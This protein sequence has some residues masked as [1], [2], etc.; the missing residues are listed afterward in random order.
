MKRYLSVVLLLGLALTMLG[1]LPVKAEINADYPYL[2]MDFENSSGTGVN[3]SHTSLAKGGAGGSAG[4]LYVNQTEDAQDYYVPVPSYDF[5]VGQRAKL[6]AWIKLDTSKTKLERQSIGYVMYGPSDSGNNSWLGLDSFSA[7]NLDLNSGEWVYVERFLTWDGAMTDGGM[8]DGSKT[9]T[10]PCNICPRVGQYASGIIKDA[11]AEDS[12]TKSICYWIDNITLE[13]AIEKPEGPVE[14][15]D[16]TFLL[17]AVFDSDADGLTSEVAKYSPATGPDGKPGILKIAG[18][19]G[20]YHDLQ[21]P[22]LP[23]KYNK[24]Y[25]ISMKAKA[26]S[27]ASVGVV[28]RAIILRSGR[29]DFTNDPINKHG[30]ADGFQYV[31]FEQELTTEWQTFTAYVKR[32][33]K[34]FDENP[35]SILFRF[36]DGTKIQK[37]SVDDV[38]VEEFNDC[39]TNGDFEDLKTDIPPTVNW[40]SPDVEGEDDNRY[41][42][43]YGWF[44]EGA[45]AEVSDDVSAETE[46]AKSAKITTI[47]ENGTVCQGVF[48][49]YN[50]PQEISFWAKGEGESVGKSVQVK[51][52]RFVETKDPDDA[53]DVPDT[54]ILGTDLT[55]RDTWQQ[56]TIPYHFE[57]TKP[58]DAKPGVGPRQPYISLLV[59]GGAADMTY[60][61]DDFTVGESKEANVF[62]FPYAED[63][64]VTGNMLAG[65]TLT[66]EYTYVS[67]AGKEQ[68][69]SFVRVVKELAGGDFVA[70]LFETEDNWFEYTIPK[71][72]SGSS[73]RFEI[74]PVA[75]DGTPGVIERVPVVVVKHPQVVQPSL[76]EFDAESASVTG[77]LYAENNAPGGEDLELFIVV[78]VYDKN[79]CAVRMNSK[80]VSIPAEDSAEIACTVSTAEEAGY[81]PIHKAKLYVWGGTDVFHTNMISYADTIEKEKQ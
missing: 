19:T 36:G 75:K 45:T 64:M 27:S 17:N 4:S 37:A 1:A 9:D 8:Y 78:A 62:P 76:S 28:P 14:E 52:D 56:Y 51:L 2:Y 40:A 22:M 46:G 69:A 41:G 47:Q 38:R 68:G 60:Y 67:E 48:L 18:K 13:P 12:P 77:S 79:G 59:N 73:I 29:L 70:G 44:E 54:E 53:Y 55:L 43:F 63:A 10:I 58:S 33:V 26:D 81:A 50:I 24:L 20:T 7:T 39:V 72:V 42:T 3:G 35:L 5:M 65:D 21:S 74:L 6:S 32:N 57:V 11:V 61:V 71:E 16:T 30:D 34:T 66:L 80:S 23:I 15:T 31:S 25:R 49:P